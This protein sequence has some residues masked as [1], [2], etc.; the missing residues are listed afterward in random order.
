MASHQQSILA[1]NRELRKRL[2]EQQSIYRRK[3]AGFQENQQRQTQLVDKL[4]EK[5][6]QYKEKCQDL[7]FKLQILDNEAK[8][9]RAE[10]ESNIAEL[11]SM[12]MRLEEEQQ[13][14]D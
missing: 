12:T 7:E 6:V 9:R 10:C 5:V 3:L 14:L 2:E 4:Q 1:E 11:E 13:R 8:T